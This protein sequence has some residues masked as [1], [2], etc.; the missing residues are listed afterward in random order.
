MIAHIINCQ[1]FGEQLAGVVDVGLEYLFGGDVV[2][3][4]STHSFLDLS[5]DFDGILLSLFDDKFN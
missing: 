5:C 4:D 1:L 2:L 3:G